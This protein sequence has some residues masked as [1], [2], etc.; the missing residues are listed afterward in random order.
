MVSKPPI[1]ISATSDLRSARDL[2]GKVLHSMGYGRAGRI[3]HRR[4]AGR[5][6]MSFA[7]G[8]IRARW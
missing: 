4:M 5:C 8:L 1:F 2:V 7:V 3:L 6:S